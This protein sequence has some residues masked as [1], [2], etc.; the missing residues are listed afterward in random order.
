MT[1]RQW[2]IEV[3]ALHPDDAENA[4]EGG[5]DR[6]QVVHLGRRRAALGRAGR[7]QRD[8][9]R[10]RPAGPGDAAA[11]RRVHD[12]GWRVRAAG[13]AWP[14][15]TSRSASRGSSFGFL[16]PD[17][18]VDVESCADAGRRLDGRAVDVRPGLRPRARRPAV[19]WRLG[20][21]AGLDGVHTAGARARH[22]RRLRRPARPRAEPPDFAA[23][24]D[25]GRRRTRPEHVPW[26]VRAGV[27]RV[28]LG[29]AVRP[30]ASWT[31]AHVDAGFVRSWRLLLDDATRG[32]GRGRMTRPAERADCVADLHRPAGL[33]CARPA[34]VA[35]RS[36]TRR[37]TS[38]TTFAAA[39]RRPAARFRA[40]PLR[41]AGRAVRRRSSRPGRTRSRRARSCS[42][43]RSSGCAG[44]RRRDGAA[45]PRHAICCDR[46]GS[47]PGRPGRGRRHLPGVVPEDRLR[48]G[49]ER[50]TSWGLDGRGSRRTCST[51]T[52]TLGYLAGTDADRAADF[53]AAWLGSRRR[54][55]LRR[56]RRLRH[57]ADAR[58]ARLAPAGGGAAPKVA[59][60][61]L[62]HHRA[63]PGGG[64]PARAGRRCTGMSSTS[65]GAATE[66]SAEAL[67]R[68]LMEPE[69]VVDLLA[70]QVADDRGRRGRPTG[71]LVGG[72]LA[73]L[74][75]EVGTPFSRPAAGGIVV[76][77]DVNEEPYRIDRHAHPARPVGLVRRRARG[78][79]RGVHR[80]RDPA[81]GRRRC[82]SSGCAR[83]A[84]RSVRGLRL[85]PHRL[86]DDQRA[87]R[88]ARRRSTPTPA[89]LRPRPRPPLA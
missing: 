21:P 35:S 51:R 87:A 88:R 39:Q 67:R 16:T 78:R 6:L 20:R 29:A 82:S 54:G 24:G 65:L 30:G 23:A 10:D 61:L 44:A 13:R 31:K 57:P 59:R 43:S 12:P 41:R 80:L 4:Q 68:L 86:D 64:L 55:G 85:R 42:G 45:A 40:R 33:A 50:L 26:L 84:S 11:L 15:T 77:E 8:R 48:A 83:S 37:S 79:A 62:R 17:L 3:V 47:Q 34:L 28:H 27:T 70:G 18:E 2:L 9:P 14:P 32:T 76:L 81:R 63:A 56:A 69:A 74:A 60:R 22:G 89:R 75:A 53:A 7:G 5:A 1:G 25:R 73:M 52:R 72:N 19:A 58:P 49:L 66:A 71:V 38:C 46:G 36:A